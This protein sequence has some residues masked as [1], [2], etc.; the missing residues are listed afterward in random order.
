MFLEKKRAHQQLLASHGAQVHLLEVA[1]FFRMDIEKSPFS[2]TVEKIAAITDT[3]HADV[4]HAEALFSARICAGVKDLRPQ[5]IFSIDW[6]GISPEEAV[7]GG[8]HSSRVAMLENTE[9]RLLAASDLNIV[10][11]Q[12]M[13]AHFREKYGDR[14]A[15]VQVPCCVSDD[16]FVA[17]EFVGPP[18][19]FAECD[20]V[21]GY[22]GSMADWQCGPEMM[23]LFSALYGVD[24]RCRFLL[25]VP[26]NDQPKARDFAE[27][28]Q[29]PPQAFCLEEVAHTEVASRLQAA[30]L[31]VLIRADDAVNRVSS[32]TKYG[33]YLAAGLPVLMT[34]CIGDYSAHGQQYGVGIVLPAARLKEACADLNLLRGIIGF[35]E[36]VKSDKPIWREKCQQSIREELS[37]ESAARRWVRA[38]CSPGKGRS[39][40]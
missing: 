22:A 12:A 25:L 16:K 28:A 18:E 34:D 23:R 17:T 10:V 39:E 2:E 14:N 29:L 27:Q 5:L 21:F 8:A 35:A 32:P 6:H 33:E 26:E 40:R 24:S 13:A 31:A 3:V 9:G 19:T 11:S 20:L 36:Q 15:W 37:W 7:M 30:D 1:D 4:L 38:Y